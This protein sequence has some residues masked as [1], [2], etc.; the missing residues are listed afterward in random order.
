[1][2]YSNAEL[3]AVLARGGGSSDMSVRATAYFR[4][5]EILAE[6][7]PIAPL[8]ENVRVT[9]SRIGIRGLPQDDARGLVPE[10]RYNLVRLPRGE[11]SR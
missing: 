6:D 8:V 9:I 5:Q 4:A 3:D 1:M 7:L 2:G 11:A 10:Y